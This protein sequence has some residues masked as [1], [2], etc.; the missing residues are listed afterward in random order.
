MQLRKQVGESGRE[1][2][3]AEKGVAKDM[4]F[5]KVGG[6]ETSKREHG[7]V[8]RGVC[9]WLYAQRRGDTQE[10][11]VVGRLFFHYQIQDDFVVK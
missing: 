9:K 6:S 11:M 2:G 10:C 1:P 5:P 7:A 3:N 4:T 8:S